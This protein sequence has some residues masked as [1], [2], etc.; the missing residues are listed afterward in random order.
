M[1]D[2]KSVL[3]SPRSTIRD[4]LTVIN[5]ARSQFAMVVDADGSLLGTLSDG[6]VRRGLLDNASLAD[7]VEKCMCRDPKVAKSGQS[8]EEILV[9][10]RRSGL[11][12]IPIVDAD[13]RVIG[14]KTVDDFL[15]LANR[16]NPVVIMAG[17]LG[18]RLH[19]LTREQP[20]P[21]LPI[22]G[23]PLLEMI[24]NRFVTQGF[25]KIWLAVNYRAEII[26]QYFGDGLAFGAD[27]RYLREDKR[28]GTA[29]ALSLLPP[30]IEQ[31]V[32]VSNAD[33]VASLDYPELLDAHISSGAVATMAVREH[34][35]PIPFGV[36]ME[37]GGRI[38][39]IEE[40]PVHR[41]LVNAGVYV[42]SPEA[43][44][45][46]PHDI[47]FDMPQLFDNLVEDRRSVFCHRLNGYWLD[48]GHR[49]DYE[50]ANADFSEGTIDAH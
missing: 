40:K 11:H 35:Y 10:M 22:G 49:K 43:I 31:P 6:D 27:I 45:R 34:E 38:E 48:I 42:L 5:T 2:W 36:V 17:G 15:C 30:E 12:Q 9:L 37:S 20:K 46:V 18:S 28:L 41:V 33:L 26:E 13:H 25:S 3:V 47:Y 32:I 4:A 8:A 1:T 14:L 21:M 50:K 16:E 29:G 39:R 19:E 44:R 24:V 23:R 7:V